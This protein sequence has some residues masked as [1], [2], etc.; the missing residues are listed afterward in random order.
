MQ[1]K[2]VEGVTTAKEDRVRE[3]RNSADMMVSRLDSHLKTKLYTLMGQKNSLIEE[4]D[5]LTALLASVENDMRA[6]KKSELIFKTKDILNK[7]SQVWKKPMASFVTA[8]VPADFTRWV[9]YTLFLYRNEIIFSYPLS[10]NTSFMPN[11]LLNFYALIWIFARNRPSMVNRRSVKAKK[12]Q[13]KAVKIHDTTRKK[14]RTDLLIAA[15]R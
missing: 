6:F 14:L 11:S 15:Q 5:T 2:N 9:N 4:T 7:F 12:N 10:S 8:P 13:R 3:I 1:E